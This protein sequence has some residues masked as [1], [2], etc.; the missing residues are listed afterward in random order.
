MSMTKL[1]ILLMILVTLPGVWVQTALSVQQDNSVESMVREVTA[2]PGQRGPLSA[3]KLVRLLQ[4]NRYRRQPVSGYTINGS[5]LMAI[6][7]R[8]QFPIR[9]EKAIIEGGLDFNDISGVVSVEIE[10]TGSE[11]RP[12]PLTRKLSAG[13]A[14]YAR[15]VTFNQKVNFSNTT[16]GGPLVIQNCVF[17]KTVD[18][19]RSQL[20]SAD[21]RKTAFKEDAGF[22]AIRFT[23]VNFE[24]S[25]FHKLAYFRRSVFESEAFLSGVQFL[26]LADFSA[27]QFDARAN[28]KGAASSSVLFGGAAKFRKAVFSQEADF[29]RVQFMDR[30]DFTDA[31]F[32]AAAIFIETV[33]NGDMQFSAAIFH[34]APLFSKAGFRK[35]VD[36]QLAKFFDGGAFDH[37]EFSGQS[38][39]TAAEF[40]GE[41]LFEQASFK[42]DALFRSMKVKGKATFSRTAFH[43][44]ADFQG[45]SFFARLNLVN[46]SFGDYADFRDARIKKLDLNCAHNPAVLSTRF[47]LR[48]AKIGQAHLEDIIFEKDVDFS[49]AD[50]GVELAWQQEPATLSTETGETVFRFITFEDT[51]SFLRTKFAGRFAMENIKFKGTA[52]FTDAEFLNDTSGDSATFMISYVDFADLRLRWHQL[53]ETRFWVTSATDRIKSSMELSSLNNDPEPVSRVIQSF[54]TIFRDRGQLADANAAVFQLKQA[55]LREARAQK[56]ISKRLWP[57]L[58]WLFWGL[59]CGYGTKIWRIICWAILVDL[60]FAFVYWLFAEI[61]RTAFPG[62]EREFSFRLRLL[63]FPKQYSSRSASL[64]IRSRRYRKFIDALRVSSVI[65]FKVGYRDTTL[66][67]PAGSFLNIEYIVALEWLLGF[68]LLAALLV[69]LANTQPLINRLLTGIF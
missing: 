33:F 36:F 68:Y 1:G 45:T 7:A 53:P 29:S 52:N 63:D 59:S 67:T 6:I 46:A 54:E 3:K 37:T 43:G 30:S 55:R 65:L 16:F 62:A 2:A 10:I 17:N 18:F 41:A 4:E 40:E 8:A 21:F 48:G 26:S 12:S 24:G 38:S 57:E 34:S 5:E 66:S 15:N 31:E 23:E 58:E 69:T 42:S 9:I 64:G 32:K 28:F 25:T 14:L 51:V 44:L 50:F 11:I 35:S 20:L 47:D 39:F 49:D 61:K 27:T 60:L 56:Q 13:T 22:D 19:H